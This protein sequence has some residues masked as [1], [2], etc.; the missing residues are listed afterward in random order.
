MLRIVSFKSI[1]FSK[2]FTVYMEIKYNKFLYKPQINVE[3]GRKQDI[4]LDSQPIWNMIVQWQNHYI[5]HI[6]YEISTTTFWQ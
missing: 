5:M 4:F 6:L 3:S 1:N 2:D